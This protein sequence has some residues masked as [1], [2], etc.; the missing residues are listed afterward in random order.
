ML[1]TRNKALSAIG[2]WA[3]PYPTGPFSPYLYADGGDG[4]GSGSGSG[5]GG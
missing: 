2:G 1:R 3:H 5:D 4:G